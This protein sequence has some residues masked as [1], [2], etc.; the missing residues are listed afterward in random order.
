MGWTS[1]NTSYFDVHQ[2]YK[3]LTHCH[4]SIFNGR[5]EIIYTSEYIWMDDFPL[6]S[7]YQRISFPRIV[8]QIHQRLGNGVWFE[9]TIWHFGRRYQKIAII[10]H[11]YIPSSQGLK[12]RYPKIGGLIVMC[13]STKWPQREGCLPF[14]DK[15]HFTHFAS[16]Y[17]QIVSKH[18]QKIKCMRG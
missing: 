9:C 15:T 18:S 1:I 3:V 13:P 2:G 6:P 4:I 10:I 12:M 5:I 14:L 17:Q 16:F 8:E 7:Q 11:G